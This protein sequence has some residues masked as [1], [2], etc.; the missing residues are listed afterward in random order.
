[1]KTEVKLIK[2]K[3]GLLGLAE[4]LGNVSQACKLFGYSRDTFYRYKDLYES[5]GELALQEASRR[6][7]NIKNRIEATI[8][9]QAVKIAFEYPAYGQVRASNELKKK[10][11]FISPA[12]IR[13]VW[14]RNNLET[15]AK[16]LKYLEKQVASEGVILTE[17]QIVAL[18][19]A[20]EEKVAHGEIETHH[21]GYLGAQDTYYVG[22]IKGVGRIY[23]QTYIDTYT[24][25][26]Q[27]KLY[28][29]KN[30]LVSADMLNDKVL[31]MYEESNIPLLRILTDRGTEYCGA[32]EHH[33]YQLYLAVEDIDH[34]KTKARHPQTNGICERFHRTMQDEFYAVAFRKKIY[35]NLD[36][37]QSDVD[38]WIKY[39]NEQRPH[40]GK[41]CF[42]KT[43]W[44]TW[45]ESLHLTKEKML[46]THYQND[47]SLRPTGET[48]TG[49]GGDQP[50]RDNLPDWNGQPG[51]E[52][53]FSMIIPRKNAFENALPR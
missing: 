20:K 39:Y 9:E 33:E 47:V 30:A 5:G 13:C 35:Q 27:A 12:G 32:R 17:A 40:S 29:R 8:E 15:F 52:P 16:R 7:P 21:P 10:G 44:Q 11:I 4:Q 28:D 45:N 51:I 43:P 2:S 14:L 50:A 26:A 31:P 25:V 42:G 34:T 19:K 38:T 41:Y 48:E 18:E 3:L 23:Q 49:S 24:R 37:L 22:T 1:M 53:R 36:E 6:K 46:N